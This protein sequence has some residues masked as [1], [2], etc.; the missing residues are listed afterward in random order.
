MMEER[1]LYLVEKNIKLDG[2][3]ALPLFIALRSQVLKLPS[4]LKVYTSNKL[5]LIP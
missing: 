2:H 5:R 3:G 1:G 4:A